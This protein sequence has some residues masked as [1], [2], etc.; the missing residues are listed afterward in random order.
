MSE[1]NPPVTY[2]LKIVLVGVSPINNI[3]ADRG[4][5]LDFRQLQYLP[6]LIS[7]TIGTGSKISRPAST[8]TLSKS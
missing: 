4:K 1:S 7:T 8:I 3:L 6:I 5:N 2:Q